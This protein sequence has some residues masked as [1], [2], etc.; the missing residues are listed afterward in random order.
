THGS[1]GSSDQV[2]LGMSTFVSQLTYGFSKGVTFFETADAYGA[3]PCIGQ[4]VSQVGRNNVV[5]LTKSEAQTAAG[6]QADLDRFRRELGV[7]MI[8]L[9]RLP[10]TP[11]ATLTTE[12]Y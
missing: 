3:H 5:V 6:M 2:R 11:C 10:N 1:N 9:V 4:A 8:D 12:D 7:G